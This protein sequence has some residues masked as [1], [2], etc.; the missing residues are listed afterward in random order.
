MT[1][2]DQVAPPAYR[3]AFAPR[4]LDAIAACNDE[5]GFAIV[6][7]AITPALA[8]EIR[9]DITATVT[10]APVAA[11]ES[12][13]DV[14]F[15]ERAPSLLKLL[16]C[17]PYMRLQHRLLGTTDLVMH[18][19]A[20]IIRQ[21][22]SPPIGWHTDM[23]LLP[24]APRS[25]NDALN[26]GEWP[27]GMWFY[28]TGSSP[29]TG[30]LAVI[31]DSHRPDWTPPAGYALSGN[32]QFVHR[33]GD[34]AVHGGMEIPGAVQLVTAANDLIV[35]A[36]RT[37]H[38]ANPHLG[39]AARLSAGMAL[40][41][42]RPRLTVPWPLPESARRFIAATPPHLRRYVDGYTGIVADW[43]PEVPAA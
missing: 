38:A 17:D 42:R 22:G 40:R 6:R 15:I 21:P 28:L 14:A 19:T 37:Y 26:R 25:A 34:Q 1:A 23:P 18:R 27:N 5:H 2:V 11:L 3:F 32:R 35:F 33:A 4:E 20:A 8:D 43:R 12:R 39:G 9:T 30:G 10:G 13:C 16:E 29:E 36:A 7:G 31:A 41:P 24:P